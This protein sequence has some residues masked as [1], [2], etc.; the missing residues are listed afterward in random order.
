[1]AR[2][3]EHLKK[4]RDSFNFFIRQISTCG[5]PGRA[6]MNLIASVITQQLDFVIHQLNYSSLEQNFKKIIAEI[7]DLLHSR[8]HLPLEMG[9]HICAEN[10]A[11]SS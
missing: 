7:P 1:M 5:S 6:S 11:H 8:F 2:I 9:N 3:S 10:E 4:F